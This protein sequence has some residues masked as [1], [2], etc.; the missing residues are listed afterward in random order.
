MSEKQYVSLTGCGHGPTKLVE[1]DRSKVFESVV[2]R[3]EDRL[4]IVYGYV[5]DTGEISHMVKKVDLDFEN[6]EESDCL[7]WNNE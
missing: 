4:D 3:S 6:S 5:D 1:G 2:A 7:F